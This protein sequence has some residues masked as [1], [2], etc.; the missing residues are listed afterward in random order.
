MF[1]P[2]QENLQTKINTIK[3]KFSFIDSIS[4]NFSNIQSMVFTNDTS[5][6]L[7]ISV[8]N[9]RTGINEITVIDL[10]WY[11]PYKPYADTIITAL[12]YLFFS[13]RVYS[14]LPNIISGVSH[15]TDSVVQISNSG[16]GKK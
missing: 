4:N 16:G 8:P 3:Q 14:G 12:I 15:V 13:W 6:S 1:I 11:A 7:T 9:N 5:T 2:N 10:S